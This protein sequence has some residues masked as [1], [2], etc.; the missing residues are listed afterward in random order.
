VKA[1]F[2]I[3]CFCVAAGA[4]AAARTPFQ[5]RCE[6]TISKTVSVL[7]SKQNGFTINNQLPYR[8]LT[9]KSGSIDG[10]CKPWG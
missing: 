2:A 10:A 9:A 6:D 5:I 7:S 1:W 8:A 3:V 4:Q